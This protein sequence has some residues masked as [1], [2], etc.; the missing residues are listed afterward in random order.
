MLNL[1]LTP[2]PLAKGQGDN[3][4]Q[5]HTFVMSWITEKAVDAPKIAA[6]RSDASVASSQLINVEDVQAPLTALHLRH[7]RLRHHTRGLI[8]DRWTA[9]SWFGVL[10]VSLDG[11][12]IE[13]D[14]DTMP[15]HGHGNALNQFEAILLQVIGPRLAKNGPGWRDTT[16]YFQ[17][18][19]E[20]GTTLEQLRQE[21]R[22]LRARVDAKGW[23]LGKLWEGR[24]VGYRRL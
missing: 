6:L 1:A 3:S 2:Q 15:P 10:D 23:Q 19:D 8:R 22:E 20:E 21:I 18:A 12:L 16:E 14:G 9:F 13:Q 4:W 17:F 5:T 11:R 24:Q 7:K